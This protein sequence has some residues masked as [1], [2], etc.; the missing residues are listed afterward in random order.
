MCVCAR[1]AF[2][3]YFLQTWLLGIQMRARKRTSRCGA[4]GTFGSALNLMILAIN[5]RSLKLSYLLMGLVLSSTPTFPPPF[6][7]KK[8]VFF[9]WRPEKDLSIRFNY[10]ESYRSN[11]DLLESLVFCGGSVSKCTRVLV[12]YRHQLLI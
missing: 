6:S 2:T 12:S 10:F 3:G 4:I 9:C 8:H 7:C 5:E 1:F 11:F